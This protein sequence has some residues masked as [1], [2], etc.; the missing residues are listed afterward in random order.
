MKGKIHTIKADIQTSCEG[1]GRKAKWA[2][3]SPLGRK[4]YFCSLCL[5]L[6]RCHKLVPHSA[7]PKRPP[8]TEG[9]WWDRL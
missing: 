6:F 3:V 2:R 9:Y 4:R 8:P 7:P 1:C 5:K